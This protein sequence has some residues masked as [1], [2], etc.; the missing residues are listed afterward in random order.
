M[1]LPNERFRAI[2]K[3][4]HFLGALCDPKRTPGVPSA[5]RDE[6]R[7]CL[8]HYPGALDMEEAIHGLRLAAQ[9]FAAVE[10]IPRRKRRP[11]ADD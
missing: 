6:A 4:R 1:T 5:I 7:R 2:S 10:P 8:K 9:V 11:P 3:T